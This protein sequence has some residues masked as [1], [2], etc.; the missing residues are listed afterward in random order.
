MDPSTDRLVLDIG[1]SRTKLGLFSQARLVRHRTVENG[2]L[3]GIRDFLGTPMRVL[4]LGCGDGFLTRAVLA[5]APETH[6]VLIDHS[7][8]Q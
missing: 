5:D 1:N 6:A 7:A 3:S 2:D 4:D 8:H